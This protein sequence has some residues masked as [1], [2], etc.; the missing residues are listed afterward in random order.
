MNVMGPSAA[1]PMNAAT[2]ST[3]STSG[4]RS[5]FVIPNISIDFAHAATFTAP[6]SFAWRR[7]SLQCC[8]AS[9]A[10][11]SRA[12]SGPASGA[13]PWHAR[14]RSFR[15]ASSAQYWRNTFTGRPIAAAPT[16]RLAAAVSLSSVP[17]KRTRERA[18]SPSIWWCSDPVL[19]GHLPVGR[20]A[21]HRANGRVEG[22][23]S[24]ALSTGGTAHDG[25]LYAAYGRT[26]ILI[27]GYTH[28]KGGGRNESDAGRGVPAA[29]ADLQGARGPE[30][31]ASH[32]P[33]APSRENGRRAVR[34]HRGEPAPHVPSPRRPSREGDREGRTR[35]ELRPLQPRRP[36]RPH[37]D[38]PAP[39]RP[40]GPARAP[41]C[42]RQRGPASAPGL[43]IRLTT[44]G[45]AVS[46]AGPTGP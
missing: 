15:N 45:W 26:Q 36:A 29:R 39:R 34:R 25:V 42:P 1:S 3:S 5:S 35:R 12:P 23:P 37:R 14:M 9:C 27:Y 22:V 8:V 24:D 4:S 33:V 46:G 32:R 7:T 11:T 20:R 21:R 28:I 18:V 41:G 44:P 38:R 19:R 13:A 16:A 40:R 10:S 43:P 30:P 31:A 6:M 2:P 17:E